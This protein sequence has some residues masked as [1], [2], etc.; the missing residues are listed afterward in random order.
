MTEKT[1]P[2]L[3]EMV[4]YSVFDRVG[5]YVRGGTCEKDLLDKQATN[6]GETVREGKFEF[7]RSPM[8]P[9]ARFKRRAAYPSV[10]DQLGAISDMAE[11]LR[12]QGIN[13]PKS[14]LEWID[15]I[16]TVKRT[17]PKDDA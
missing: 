17:Y 3:V 5:I 12:E 6:E 8:I 2:K 13:L 11:A 15:K 16:Q 7:K 14:T 10:G 9:S 1:K 4:Q